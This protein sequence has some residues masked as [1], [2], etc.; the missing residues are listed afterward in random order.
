MPYKYRTVT[1]DLCKNHQHSRSEAFLIRYHMIW[2]PER[3]RPIL[4]G[5]VRGEQTI[6]QVVD[7]LK[8]K[9]LEL[10]ITHD[11]IHSFISAYST[12]PIH[13]ILRRIKGEGLQHS[14]GRVSRTA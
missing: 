9:V 1:V 4:V 6:H 14:Q 10:A 3:L 5:R 7:E 12:I 2:C 13:K 8:I 11:H